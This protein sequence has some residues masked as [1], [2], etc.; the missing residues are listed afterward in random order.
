MPAWLLDLI[1]DAPYA[2]V[3]IVAVWLVVKNWCLLLSGTIAALHPDEKR[4]ADAREVMRILRDQDPAPLDAV[5]R[6]RPRGRPPRRALRR[7]Q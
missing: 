7:R 5:T 2:A 6:P 1:K 3:P 4:R